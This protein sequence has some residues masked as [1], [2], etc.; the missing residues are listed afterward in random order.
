MH[1][2]NALVALALG[3]SFV[4]CRSAQYRPE[5][6]PRWDLGGAQILTWSADDEAFGQDR[7]LEASGLTAS[8]RFL[9]ATSEKYWRVLQIDPE[10]GLAA[11]V[12]ALEVPRHTELEGIAFADGTLFLC[13]EAHAAVY[14]VDLQDESATESGSLPA[15]SLTL[16]GPTVA[17][18]KIGLEGLAVTP[19]GSRL[20]LLLERSGDPASGCVSTI[21]PLA[22]D[23]SA[24]TATAD[25]IVVELADCNWRLT[26][27]QL[28][29]D[30]L[31]AL[32][33]Q[34][35]GERYEV[36]EI[37][38]DSGSW[39]VVLEM[40]DFLRSV[41]QDG[42]NNNVEGITVTPD[43][44]LWLI[45]DNAWTEVIDASTPPIADERALLV[46]IPPAR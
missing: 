5:P 25:P 27:L 16:E 35:P 26:G 6:T 20:W 43:G 41:R 17:A 31:L 42:W 39:S 13:D 36:I 22:I 2:R 37:D 7:A 10:Q 24:L 38:P 3:L 33:T 23:D 28:W 29:K 9:Y 30:R 8:D 12:I 4:S 1:T 32:K 46:R 19:D 21:Y 18:G 34:Y 40:T 44:S 14:R 11:R 15:R 45:S